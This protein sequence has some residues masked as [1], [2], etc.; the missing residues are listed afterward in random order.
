MARW[1]CRSLAAQWRLSL[2]SDIFTKLIHPFIDG[3]FREWVD[4]LGRHVRSKAKV[5]EVG[6]AGTQAAFLEQLK[7]LVG[8]KGQPTEGLSTTQTQR[9]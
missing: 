3:T 7:G 5:G 4:E 8:Q 1:G 9:H 2:T 6:K